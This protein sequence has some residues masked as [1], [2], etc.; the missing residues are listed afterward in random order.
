MGLPGSP[1][2]ARFCV[3]CGRV[4][5]QNARFCVR[6]G[7]RFED[8]LTPPRSAALVVATEQAPGQPYPILCPLLPEPPQTPATIVLRLMLSFPILIGPPLLMLISLLVGVPGWLA[9][10]ML[11]AALPLLVGW[12]LMMLLSLVVAVPAWLSALALGRLPAPIHRFQAVTLRYV[13]RTAAYLS[14]AGGR[15][16]PFPWQGAGG[17]PQ[18][19]VARPAPRSRLKTLLV[20]PLALP[21]VITAVLFGVVTWMLG[22]GAWFALLVS[23]R[24]PATIREMLELAIG[25]Q[26][27]TLGYFPLLLTDVYPWYESGPL[28][29]ASR[30]AASTTGEP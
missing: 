10:T 24:L 17:Y 23:G 8:Q 20:L 18:I 7:N 19:A 13:T 28:M 9:W 29:L 3:R 4:R 2:I 14:L 22:V 27:R 11:I 6:C 26:C 5:E 25:F 30:R 12:A 16:P 21:A 15:W 1:P